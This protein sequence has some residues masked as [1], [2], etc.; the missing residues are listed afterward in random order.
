MR[1]FRMKKKKLISVLLSCVFIFAFFVGCGEKKTDG[2]IELLVDMHGYMPTLNEEPT[3]ENPTVILSTRRIQEAFEAENP[4][5]KITWARSKPVGGLEAEVSQWFVTQIA[6]DNCPA[7]AFSW[8]TGYQDRDYYVDLTDYYN[9]PNEYVEGNEKW[10]DLFEDYLFETSTIKDI[11]GQLVGVPIT[12]YAGP[13][14]GW[15]YNKDLITAE[16][17]PTNWGEF[18][19]LAKTLNEDPEVTAVA[20]WSYFKKISLDNWIMQ[21][22]IGPAIGAYIM[23]Q[24]D[25]DGNGVTSTMEQLRAMKAGIYDPTEHDYA[26]EVYIQAKRYFTELLRDGWMNTDYTPM[27]NAGNVAMY[28]EGLWGLYTQYNNTARDF[29]FGVFPAPLL[30]KNTTPY[31]VDIEYTEK[32][33]YQPKGDMILNIMKPAVEG[34]PELEEA[35]V[36]FLKFLTTPDNISM[37]AEEMGSVLGS[38]KGSSYNSILDEWLDQSFPIVPETNW[39]L[40]FNSEQ[41][42]K[43][44]RLFGEWVLGRHSDSEFYAQVNTIQQAGAD[45]YIADLNIDT[46]GWN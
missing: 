20:P 30:D 5:I 22:T 39:P 44:N 46:S 38:V 25:Y 12:L 23:E 21:F 32:G 7:I 35:A 14:T 27:W 18:V 9:E 3:A 45:A 41:N 4:N 26:K 6:G 43:L 28:E 15:Y 34:K 13:A 29:D 40:A 1:R 16:Q 36:K 42:D 31:A 33:P 37:I 17:V 8:G 2:K 10:S 24:T 19:T 11:K